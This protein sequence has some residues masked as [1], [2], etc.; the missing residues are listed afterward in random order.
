MCC[1]AC[2]CGIGSLSTPNQMARNARAKFFGNAARN[3]C[4]GFVLFFAL[5]AL[6]RF[7]LWA[8]LWCF[9]EYGRIPVY[10]L[11]YFRCRFAFVCLAL[12]SLFVFGRGLP[13]AFVAASVRGFWF[14]AR[15]LRL[16]W[17]GHCSFLGI[18]RFKVS[19]RWQKVSSVQSNAAATHQRQHNKA[20]HPTAYSSVPFA[21]ASLRS[22]RFRRR[23][24]LVVVPRASAFRRA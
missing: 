10:F 23:V 3:S 5:L 7:V 2:Q 18:R 9:R 8:R 13:G 14:S 22:L 16:V 6:N 12:L 24:S 15:A 17:C 20:L 21:R 1:R 4:A 11:R 19:R